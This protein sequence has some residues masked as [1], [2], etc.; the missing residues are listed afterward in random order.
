MY[1]AEDIMYVQLWHMTQYNNNY[2]ILSTGHKSQYIDNNIFYMTK[3][4][5]KNIIGKNESEGQGRGLR[6]ILL[7][8]SS[9]YNISIF[10]ITDWKRAWYNRMDCLLLKTETIFLQPLWCDRNQAMDFLYNS[11][12]YAYDEI[13]LTPD[14]R[15]MYPMI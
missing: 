3:V 12:P 15:Y 10:Q 4:T 1:I 9:I 2:M 5:E 7:I 8:F 14:S 6:H 13:P 11:L